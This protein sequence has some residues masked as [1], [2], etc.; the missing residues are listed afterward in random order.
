MATLLNGVTSDTTGSGASHSGPC[1][2]FVR[3]DLGGGTVTIQVS[4][5]NTNFVKADNVSTPNPANFKAPGSLALNC[6]GTY[7]VRAI[8]EGSTSPSCTVVTTQ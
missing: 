2:V 7:Y 8:L 3:G 4:D 5:D 1:S 6:Q